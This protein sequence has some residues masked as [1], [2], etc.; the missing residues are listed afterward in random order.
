MAVVMTGK[1]KLESIKLNNP[2]RDGGFSIMKSLCLRQ[3]AKDTSKWSEKE[4]S[5]QDL[6]DL[7]W[8]GNGINREDGKR[9][10][11]SAI[12][13]QDVDI[14]V[15]RKD[16]IFIYD[17]AGHSLNPVVSGDHRAEIGMGGPRPAGSPG[18]APAA[19]QIAP[20]GGGGG[21]GASFNY[22]IKL[23][24]VSENA[25]F[26]VGTIELKSEWG[27][28]DAGLVAQNIMLFCSGTGLVAHPKAAVDF[29]GKIKALLKLTDTQHAAIELDIGY[30]IK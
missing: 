26:K 30:P 7:L 18:A 20:P 21:A 10:A 4:L 14:Y 15:L 9:T 5:L 11:A 2:E 25:R 22:P 12:N 28:F 16:G 8:A 13:S 3:S 27:V 24:I 1:E 6:S 17:A 23:L 19:G 29:D